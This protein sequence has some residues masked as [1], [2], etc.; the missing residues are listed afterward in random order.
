MCQRSDCP[1]F[2]R[3]KSETVKLELYSLKPKG[4]KKH[5]WFTLVI[6]TL[7]RTFHLRGVFTKWKNQ[8]GFLELKIIGLTTSWMLIYLNFFE[9][10]A[11]YIRQVI[12][13]R[14]YVSPASLYIKKQNPKHTQNR[15][16]LCPQAGL[17]LAV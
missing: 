6:H 13:F 4:F 9:P 1:S 12:Y 16:L 14:A 5:L 11:F 2:G 8:V 10:R 7:T 17:C 3:Q 15:I